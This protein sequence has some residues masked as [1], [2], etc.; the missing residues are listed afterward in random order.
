MSPYIAGFRRLQSPLHGGA[1]T[2]AKVREKSRI[3]KW[4]HIQWLHPTQSQNHAENTNM[5]AQGSGSL[6]VYT[7]HGTHTWLGKF[8]R[9]KPLASD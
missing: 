4:F 7:D 1:W 5:T 3:R 6:T 2:K 8:L 9:T